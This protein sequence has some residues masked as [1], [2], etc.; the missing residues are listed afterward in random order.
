VWKLALL[1]LAFVVFVRATCGPKRPARVTPELRVT[2]SDEV[3]YHNMGIAWDGRNYWTVNGGNDG[4]SRVN[5]YTRTGEFVES[6]DFGLDGRAI[7]YHAGEGVP[8][9]KIYGSALYALEPDDEDTELLHD[10]ELESDQG[11]VGFSPD[12]S[13]IYEFDDGTVRVL[14]TEDGDELDELEIEDYYGEESGGYAYAIAASDKFLFTWKSETE[15]NVHDFT[16]RFVTS[17]E[18]PRTGFGFSLSYCNRLLWI[19]E[20]ADGSTEGAVGKWYGYRLPG[21]E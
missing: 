21:L 3:P 7:G 15:I 14:A 4:Y 11:S 19:A 9:V 5:R 18:L 13:R 17:F 16:G 6:Y 2:I 1:A 20:D 8:V 10:D 12:G